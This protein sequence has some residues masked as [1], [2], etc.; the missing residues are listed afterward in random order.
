MGG[1]LLYALAGTTWHWP[2]LVGA[3]V[4]INSLSAL[5]S[6]SFVAL[7]AE[8]VTA[9]RRGTAF[10]VFQLFIGGAVALGPALGVILLPRLGTRVLI[11][12][13]A[14]AGLAVAAWRQFYL[15]ET[16][17]VRESRRSFPVREAFRGPLLLVLLIGTAFLTLSAIT[18]YG[19]FIS[20]Y[21]RD[22]QGLGPEQINILF[23][24]GP[25]VAVTVSLAG[26]RFIRMWGARRVMAAAIAGHVLTLL[27]W[28]RLDAF[29]PAAAV[30]ALAIFFFQVG[31]IAYD[32]LRSGVADE[33]N[34]GAALGVIGTVSGLLSA[35]GP[36]LAGTLKSRYGPASPF[37]LA[38]AIG[39]ALVILLRGLPEGERRDESLPEAIFR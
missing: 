32:T 23:A 5:Q 15:V 4:A 12:A 20:L 11:L 25:L 37:W 24:V 33:G 31:A 7:M 28:L 10:A 36:P 3:L 9:D 18:A 39:I 6:P 17:P 16:F 29:I 1:A 21:A 38:A 14:G 2:V 35:I 13:T 34:R 27:F 22:V 26:G 8:S 19:P 30:F